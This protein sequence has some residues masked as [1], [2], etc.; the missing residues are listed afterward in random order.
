MG[1]IAWISADDMKI[2][3]PHFQMGGRAQDKVTVY[4]SKANRNLNG[5]YRIST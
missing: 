5:A 2:L 4:P 3:L 1:D